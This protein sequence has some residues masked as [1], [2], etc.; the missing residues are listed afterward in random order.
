MLCEILDA[1]K[2]FSLPWK[3]QGQLGSLESPGYFPANTDEKS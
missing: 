1:M 2:G 3:I